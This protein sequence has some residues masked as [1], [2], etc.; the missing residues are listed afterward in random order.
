MR[1]EAPDISASLMSFGN[2]KTI[3]IPF[4]IEDHNCQNANESNETSELAE[5]PTSSSTENPPKQIEADT[6]ERNSSELEPAS[7]AQ[8]ALST[9]SYDQL[10]EG[11][12]CTN[13][14]SNVSLFHDEE[15]WT[16]GLKNI[17]VERTK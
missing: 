6:Y 14:I 1:F 12:V 8:S 9:S 17:E 10:N 5:Q 11:Q 2:I 15:Q 16:N 13:D 7:Q 3:K 4:S